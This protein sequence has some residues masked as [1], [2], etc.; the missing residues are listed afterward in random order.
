MASVKNKVPDTITTAAGIDPM[1]DTLNIVSTGSQ[2]RVGT[3]P[4]RGG[5]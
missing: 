1:I 5:M 4:P 3:G 2:V